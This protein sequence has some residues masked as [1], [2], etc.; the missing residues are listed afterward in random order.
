MLI[1]EVT[2]QLRTFTAVVRVDL[3]GA[4]V[5]VQTQINAAGLSQAR[6]LFQHLYGSKNLVT[7]V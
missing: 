3:N 2:G 7:V 4:R 1:K 5:T 6:V